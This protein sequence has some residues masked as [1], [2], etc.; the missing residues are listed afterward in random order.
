M[1]IRNTKLE[2][3]SVIC[4]EGNGR[5]SENETLNVRVALAAG[6]SE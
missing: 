2:G 6:C 1:E 5:V 3:V 4:M